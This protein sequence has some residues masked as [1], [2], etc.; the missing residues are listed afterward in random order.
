MATLL[1]GAPRIIA[2]VEEKDDL[3]PGTE[4]VIY[5]DIELQIGPKTQ[6]QTYLIRD[7]PDRE[8]HKVR[9]WLARAGGAG[10]FV[11]RT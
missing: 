3:A 8:L 9:I 2:I 1:R 10:A 7:V 6:S 11:A 4:T 5:H